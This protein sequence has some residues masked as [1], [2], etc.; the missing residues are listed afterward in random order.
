[1]AG[2]IH[3]RVNPGWYGW[4]GDFHEVRGYYPP[5]CDREYFRRHN[6]NWFMLG[7]Q[8]VVPFLE[9]DTCN[10]KQA[11]LENKKR[12]RIWYETYWW[13]DHSA[14]GDR[15]NPKGFAIGH[16]PP[17]VLTRLNEKGIKPGGD[18]I[19]GKDWL[20]MASDP[21]VMASVKK[22]IQW[23]LDTII[24]HCGRDALYGVILSEEEPDHGVHSVLGQKGGSYYSSHRAEVLPALIKVHNELYDFIKTRYPWLK[25]SPGFYPNWV[26]PGTLKMD[27]VVMDL[28][29]PPGKEEQYIESWGNAYP[30]DLE[31]YIILWGYGDR[32][33]KMECQRFERISRGLLARGVKNLGVFRAELALQDKIHR[34]FDV[35]GAGDYEPYNLERHRSNVEELLKETTGIVRQL[36][37]IEETGLP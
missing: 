27:A 37:S 8:W 9:S 12:A 28:Y 2:N 15:D 22:T 36:R 18:N 26:E 30:F 13:G 31:Q 17:F 16:I 11:I 32:D 29:P 6:I 35:H 19:I 21:A 25:V 7:H 5:G 14:W 10:V 24:K 33:R 20:A 1:M 23:Q 3:T 34:F 4:L